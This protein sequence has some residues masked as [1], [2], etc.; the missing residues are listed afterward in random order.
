MQVCDQRD[1]AEKAR[2]AALAELSQARAELDAIA[3]TCSVRGIPTAHDKG[4]YTLAQRVRLLADDQEQDERYREKYKTELDTAIKH[5]ERLG[6][7]V[8]RLKDAISLSGPAR[9]RLYLQTRLGR[10]VDVLRRLLGEHA[11][12]DE[13]R[14]I[15]TE[16]ESILADATATA[17]A[18]RV[19]L[20]RE[21][22]KL[23]RSLSGGV[24]P[25]GCLIDVVLRK[26]AALD[27]KGGSDEGQ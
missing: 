12:A 1:E 15:R 5:A 24:I 10:A 20:W 22:E 7:E 17:A 19:P 2:D 13:F 21:L 23:V 11:N 26:L 14:V 27:E 16:A 4:P 9:E 6:E 3:E 8:A 18:D 25:V